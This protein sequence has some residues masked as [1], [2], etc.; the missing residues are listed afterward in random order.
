[1]LFL[2]RACSFR[3]LDLRTDPRELAAVKLN[4]SPVVLGQFECSFHVGV[5]HLSQG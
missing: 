4:R 1:M 5:G 2:G 3:K